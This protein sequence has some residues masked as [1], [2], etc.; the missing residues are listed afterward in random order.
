MRDGEREGEM[1]REPVPLDPSAGGR[2]HD[3]ISRTCLITMGNNRS[4]LSRGSSAFASH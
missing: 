1:E 3:I 4:V 2:T